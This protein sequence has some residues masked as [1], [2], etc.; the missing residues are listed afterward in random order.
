MGLGKRQSA[1]LVVDVQNDFM[2]GG[3]LGVSQGTEIIEPIGVAMSAGSF[4]VIVATQDWHPTN[5]ISFAS[6]HPGRRPMETIELYGRQQTLW[7]D[8]CVQGTRGAE[9]Y[10]RLPWERACAIIRKAI[11]PAIDSYSAIRNNWNAQ[12][13]RPPTGLAGLLKNLGV[14][15][16]FICGLA[17]DYCVRWTAEDAM[18]E[19]FRTTL[20][21]DLCRPI[22]PSSDSDVYKALT[23]IGVDI[24]NSGDLMTQGGSR[25]RA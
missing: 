1:M 24:I 15:S 7:P 23:G 12:G 9:L 10:P 21:W 20:L 16:V 19:G 4:D 17:R 6:N 8:H 18:A 22:D 11:D 14:E 3:A 2:P 5:H 13:E 25:L